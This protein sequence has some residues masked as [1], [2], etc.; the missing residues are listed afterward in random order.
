ME[1]DV[2]DK[3]DLVPDQ[4]EKHE[5][6]PA[7]CGDG[8]K[9]TEYDACQRQTLNGVAGAFLEI[10]FINHRCL[11]HDSE[12]KHACILKAGVSIFAQNKRRKRQERIKKFGR[13]A[14]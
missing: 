5:Q 3:V 8:E 2:K 11:M 6:L 1:K 13:G 9:G 10:D 12:S 7:Q 4:Q 14:S